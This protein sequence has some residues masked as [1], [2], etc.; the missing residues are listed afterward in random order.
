M[1]GQKGK[2]NTGG[3]MRLGNYP[4]VIEKSSIVAKLYG[5]KDIIERH[6]HRYECNNDYRDTISRVGD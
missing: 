6:R 4:C 2:E 3:T 1:D 5:S